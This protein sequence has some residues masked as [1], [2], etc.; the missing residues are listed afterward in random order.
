MEK[1]SNNDDAIDEMMSYIKKEL[2]DMELKIKNA[3]KSWKRKLRGLINVTGLFRHLDGMDGWLPYGFV[4]IY[5]AN[6]K[7]AGYESHQ[8][9]RIKDDN[10]KL[11]YI[12][13]SESDIRGVDHYCVCETVEYMSDYYSGYLLYPLKNGLYFKVS[14]SLKGRQIV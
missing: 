13:K 6:E 14:Y 9:F 10:E 1:Y 4:E 3:E 12:K 7:M 2:G 11:L 5:E 8:H